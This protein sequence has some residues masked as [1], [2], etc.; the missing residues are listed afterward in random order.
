MFLFIYLKT[1]PQKSPMGLKIRLKFQMNNIIR[2]IDN[3]ANFEKRKTLAINEGF[4]LG[5]YVVGYVV[6]Y[7]EILQAFTNLDTLNLS[8]LAFNMIH[9]F[10]INIFLCNINPSIV[11]SSIAVA[12]LMKSFRVIVILYY[13]TLMCAVVS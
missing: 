4:L 3:Y 12:M 10:L 2:C 11:L 9:I 1:T 8:L 7:C 5:G 6:G 13:L